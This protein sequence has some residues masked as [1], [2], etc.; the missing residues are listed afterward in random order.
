M[1]V[2]TVSDPGQVRIIDGYRDPETHEWVE[3]ECRILKEDVEDAKAFARELIQETD[4]KVRQQWE[5][6]YYKQIKER[7]S[8]QV[9]GALLMKVW[10][11]TK[12]T[13]VDEAKP[14]SNRTWGTED[15]ASVAR[16]IK[17]QMGL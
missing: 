13:P 6:D 11:W 5:K 16:K 14:E 4:M 9:A 17:E 2:T 1:K 10:D 3:G 12:Q 7:Y 15:I 8:A